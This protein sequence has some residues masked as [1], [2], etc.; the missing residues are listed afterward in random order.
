MTTYIMNDLEST[1]LK[2]SQYLFATL[3]QLKILGKLYGI[4][5][6]GEGL[7]K[8]DW[9]DNLMLF[10]PQPVKIWDIGLIHNDS[11]ICLDLVLKGDD[12]FTAIT[13]F[14]NPGIIERAIIGRLIELG[15]DWRDYHFFP[16]NKEVSEGFKQS[17]KSL[18]PNEI[19][20]LDKVW[21]IYR[22]KKL[23][24]ETEFLLTKY[25]NIEKTGND[26]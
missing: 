4:K 11:R 20:A 21:S 23:V 13:T 10:M 22:I 6:A 7:H 17:Y 25:W 3:E 9:V 1:T 24:N 5:G 15:S 2:R 12:I 18:L 26:G 16:L 14:N 8:V 19:H